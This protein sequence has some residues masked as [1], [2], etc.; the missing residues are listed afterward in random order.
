MCNLTPS[1][2][3]QSKFSIASIQKFKKML[4]LVT[5]K[6]LVAFVD[7]NMGEAFT[8]MKTANISPP[9]AD[10]GRYILTSTN[11]LSAIIK[12]ITNR[13][14]KES[15]KAISNPIHKKSWAR[16]RIERIVFNCEI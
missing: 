9:K 13:K 11:M 10:E 2:D 7:E 8:A 3:L 12:N 6:T 5:F 14:I 16:N 1:E 15:F 4:P